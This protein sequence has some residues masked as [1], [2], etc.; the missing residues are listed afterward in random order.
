VITVNFRDRSTGELRYR[1]DLPCPP[2]VS[3]QVEFPSGRVVIVTRVRW[4][5]NDCATGSEIDVNIKDY[6][7]PKRPSRPPVEPR[8]PETWT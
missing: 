3:E 2:R 6:V 4:K 5:P 1:S 7:P 8:K